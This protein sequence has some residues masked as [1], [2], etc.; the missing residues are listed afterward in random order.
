MK[1]TDWKYVVDAGLFVCVVGIAGIG[2]LMGFALGEGPAVEGGM[3]KYFL[4]LHRH[5]W[6]EIHFLLSLAF[7]V[8]LAVH[9]TLG[10]NWIKGKSRMLFKKAWPIG[11]ALLVVLSAL[12]LFFGWAVSTKNDPSYEDYGAGPGRGRYR[13]LKGENEGSLEKGPDPARAS[14]AA[15]AGD[16]GTVAVPKTGLED[17]GIVTRDHGEPG[18]EVSITGQMTLRDVERATGVRAA[19]IAR[20]LDLPVGV[21][22]DES[23]GRLRRRYGFAIQDVRDFVAARRKERGS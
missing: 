6:G 3:S 7:I 1:R 19:D 22:L 15:D 13:E 12:V 23:L 20:H 9:L 5:Q 8:L 14:A 11:P 10:W 16:S 21:S 17:Q 18:L 2:L 4:G